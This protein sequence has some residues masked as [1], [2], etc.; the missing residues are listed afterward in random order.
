MTGTR[1]GGKQESLPENKFVREWN[2]MPEMICF[3][4]RDD[5]RVRL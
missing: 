3:F 2:A 4:D 5:D 1:Q